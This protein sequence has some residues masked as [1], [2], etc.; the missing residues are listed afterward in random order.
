[1]VEGSDDLRI[2]T[3]F[4]LSRLVE[5]GVLESLGGGRYRFTQDFLHEPTRA[6]YPQFPEHTVPL[7]RPFRADTGNVIHL[8]ENQRSGQNT[9]QFRF[10]LLGSYAAYDDAL[11]YGS[12]SIGD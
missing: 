2:F 11:V 8:L 5:D 3:L 10:E 1:M 7:V 6:P 12:Y 9:Y 4:D